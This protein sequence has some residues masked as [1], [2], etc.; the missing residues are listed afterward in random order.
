MTLLITQDYIALNE[1]M[2]VS[3]EVERMWKE[4]AMAYCKVLRFE[5]G[6]SWIQVR[7]STTSANMLAYSPQW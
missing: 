7:S 2:T 5:L 6:T 3:N 1:W 4:A